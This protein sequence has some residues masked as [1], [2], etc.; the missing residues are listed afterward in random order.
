MSTD[1]AARGAYSR[2]MV[3]VARAGST[4]CGG[5]QRSTA[6]RVP[7]DAVLIPSEAGRGIP[8]LRH[9]QEM[10]AGGARLVGGLDEVGR[11]AWAGPLVVAAVAVRDDWGGAAHLKGVRD[12][13]RLR[14]PERERLVGNILAA[15][16]D[17]AVGCAS[18]AEC[19]EFGMSDAQRVA[20]ARALESLAVRPEGVLLD[21]RW[22]FVSSV[23]G[24]P[25]EAGAGFEGEVRTVVG[26]DSRCLSVAAASV[27]AKVWRDR[28]MVRD[29]VHYPPY[30]FD[31]N[32]GYPCPRHR[33]ALA[34]WGP[35]A[36]HRR[37]WAFMEYV[38]SGRTAGVRS[39]VQLR[40]DDHR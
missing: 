4:P 29:A 35:S 15:G 28:R 2:R 18:A 40:L 21:G 24:R 25:G 6:I 36:I 8:D 16:L 33:A 3:R 22:D 5:G 39:D 34:A 27:L 13:K 30:D 7:P 9:E 38:P 1:P 37:S 17:W 26:G 12:S 11:G 31:R 23:P 14:P 10:W 19:D 32:K 20:A